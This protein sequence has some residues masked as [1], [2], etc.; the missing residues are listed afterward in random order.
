MERFEAFIAPLVAVLQRLH[1]MVHVRTPEV[2]VRFLFPLLFGLTETV[3][4]RDRLGFGQG[5]IAGI[6]R[7]LCGIFQSTAS[8]KSYCMV[9]DAI[10]PRHFATLVQAAEV[11][12]VFQTPLS[13][14]VVTFLLSLVSTGRI[15]RL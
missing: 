14:S 7:D 9:F 2:M 11:C 5:A 6:C 8:R 3:M 15:N 4:D 1:G 10:F 12:A 13:A